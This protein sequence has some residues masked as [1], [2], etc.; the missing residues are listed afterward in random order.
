MEKNGTRC[1]QTVVETILENYYLSI[2]YGIEFVIGLLGNITVV[3]G[4]IFYLKDWKSCNI[5]L[6]NLS[7]SDLALL[8]TLPML[9]RSYASGS[10]T[11]GVVL[12]K[13]NRYILHA[14]MYTSILFLTF[15][16]IDRYLLM[17]YPFREQFLQKKEVAI[18]AS[19]TI[20]ILVTIEIL[21]ILL[22]L[23]PV[24]TE[25]STACLDYAS[26]GD[27][28]CNLG[29]SLFLTFFGFIIPLFVMCFFYLKIVFFLKHRSQQISSALPL[30]RPLTL[31]IMAMVIF[32]VLFTP[33]HVMRN[34]R[35]A[36]RLDTWA[37][38][39]SE[40]STINSFYIITRPIAFLNSV[41]N[42][43][44]YFLIGDNFREML[45]NNVQQLFQSIK[46]FRR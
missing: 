3:W 36:S 39:C 31:I 32:S 21:P 10:W 20:W 15:I 8:C 42:P 13:S 26:S 6:F 25:N 33:Y 18:V 23:E 14:N 46:S 34:V 7:L 41:I 35:I 38:S 4:Y 30:E 45:L 1:N 29:Y 37:G 17:K 40:Q 19:V 24:I 43:V 44:F 22:I 11:Y 5:Y 9:V 28:K 12:C 27:P 2:M 16:S